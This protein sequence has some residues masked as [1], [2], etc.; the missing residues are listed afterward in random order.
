MEYS[1]TNK[2]I[3]IWDLLKSC[4]YK[5]PISLPYISLVYLY[6]L[7]FYIY[8]NL[9]ISS[10]FIEIFMYLHGID[11]LP[12]NIYFNL[13]AITYFHQEY[14]KRDIKDIISDAPKSIEFII[15]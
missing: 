6:H 8:S 1:Q 4:N 7:R 15:L 11:A 2:W 14:N 5:N 12:L 10:Q 3:K 9:P 13:K